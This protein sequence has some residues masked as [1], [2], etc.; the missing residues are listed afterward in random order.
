MNKNSLLYE[1]ENKGINKYSHY[2][3]KKIFLLLMHEK[4][5]NSATGEWTAL[6][7]VALKGLKDRLIACTQITGK[8]LCS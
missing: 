1:S 7:F 4:T 8:V 3:V 2:F 6:T 5:G